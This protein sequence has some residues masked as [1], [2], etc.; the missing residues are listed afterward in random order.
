M[1]VLPIPMIIAL[2]LLALLVHRMLTRETQPML[3]A[4]IA[5]SAVQSAIIALV[6]YYGIKAI[7]PLQPLF[8]TLIP[9]IAWL[10]FAQATG[11]KPKPVSLLFHATGF[12]LALLCLF[13]QSQLLDVLI[14]SQFAIYG[15]AMLLRLGRGEGSLPHSRLESGAMPLLAW[16][17][18]AIS[19]I[20]SA[21][22]DMMIS[23]FLARG[24]TGVLLWM[25]SVFSSL[26]LLSLGALSLSH[27]IESQRDDENEET[28]ISPEDAER[29]QSTVIK[30]DEYV[31]TQKPFLDPDLTLSRLSRKLLIPAKQLSTS[32]N[33]IKG[34]NVSR[35]IN[36]HRIDHACEMMTS[37]KSVTDAML[38]SGFNTKSNF[39][40]EFLRVKGENPSKWLNNNSQRPQQ[41]QA[42]TH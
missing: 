41:N 13:L 36:R 42:L 26:T 24:E 14:P 33:R 38:S 39:N 16:R 22:S 34:E 9:P 7:H 37:G 32:I 18:I 23:Y 25:P 20:A 10:A 15:V 28:G 1:P 2:L 6:Q 30:V 17:I 4:L 5:A 35:Y 27:A 19:L 21:A 3:L 31:R 40:R 12:V 29:D 8:V 11:D